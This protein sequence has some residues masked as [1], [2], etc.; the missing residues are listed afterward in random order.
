MF[1]ISGTDGFDGPCDA[2]GAVVDSYLLRRGYD[3]KLSPTEHLQENNS[4]QYFKAN[5]DGAYHI[6]TGHTETNVMDLVLI[7]IVK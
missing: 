5:A 6:V 2:A 1:T 4:Y 3:K 7:V